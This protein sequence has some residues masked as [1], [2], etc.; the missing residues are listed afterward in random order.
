[1]ILEGFLYLRKVVGSIGE[2]IWEIFVSKIF[3][4]WEWSC[5][6]FFHGFGWVMDFLEATAKSWIR[7]ELN[8]LVFLVFRATGATKRHN[9][10]TNR[11]STS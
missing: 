3:G 11:G 6:C 2:G 7:V 9:T 4:V 10:S 1:M 5:M 8:S